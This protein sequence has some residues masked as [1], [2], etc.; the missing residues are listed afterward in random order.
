MKYRDVTKL[1]YEKGQQIKATD[2]NT[3]MKLAFNKFNSMAPTDVAPLTT[4]QFRVFEPSVG[5]QL[6]ADFQAVDNNWLRVNVGNGTVT[7]D[8]TWDHT[9]DTINQYFILVASSLGAIDSFL[10]VGHRYS[11]Y[12]NMSVAGVGSGTVKVFLSNSATQANIITAKT[13][14]AAA[15]NF[16]GT[17]S[18]VAKTGYFA[19]GSV[20]TVAPGAPDPF[21]VTVN[22]VTQF[23]S[24]VKAFY[25]FDWS[26]NKWIIPNYCGFMHP[27]TADVTTGELRE[28]HRLICQA[29]QKEIDTAQEVLNYL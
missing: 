14:S 1:Q 8:F 4:G 28:S 17:Y 29:I 22:P 10:T 11:V 3:Q 6:W 2:V 19:I 16:A 24:T 26:A 20:R 5:W 13:S 7:S 9:N 12:F 27:P 18:F 23:D 15:F 21:T 25:I